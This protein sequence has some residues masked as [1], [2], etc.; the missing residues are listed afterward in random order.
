MEEFVI[1]EAIERIRK[2]ECC[3]DVLQAAA[4]QNPAAILEDNSLKEL[5]QGLIRYYENGQWSRDYELDERG[6]LPQNLKRGVLSQDGIYDLLDRI[7]V[8]DAGPT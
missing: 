7:S 6:Y 4:T 8:H 2:M 1:Q 3:F 5:L